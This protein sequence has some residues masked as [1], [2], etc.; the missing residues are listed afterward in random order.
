MEAVIFC[1][2]QASGK[3]TFYRERF[4]DTHVRINLDM[5]KTRHRERLLLGA[6]LE[7]QQRFVA[8]NTN[9]TAE[10]RRRYIEAA[11]AAPF[12]I[13]GYYFETRPREAIGR[14]HQRP[15]RES[16]PVVGILGTYKRLE[17]PR[18]EEGFGEL[19]R[20]QIGRGGG[21][22]VDEMTDQL[23]IPVARDARAASFSSRASDV[24][25][26]PAGRDASGRE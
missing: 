9:P 17:V 12:R 23:E 2:I 1:G 18:K 26:A 15:H 8:D 25:L 22:V 14:N 24:I 3:S 16:V 6:C 5:L 10:E 21:F 11:R 7:V 13:V 20:V 4:F 19:Y